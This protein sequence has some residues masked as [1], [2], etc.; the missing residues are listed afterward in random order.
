MDYKKVEK[1]WKQKAFDSSSPRTLSFSFSSLLYSL[2]LS[3]SISLYFFTTSFFSFFS[4]LSFLSFLIFSLTLFLLQPPTNFSPSFSFFSLSL[5]EF[6]PRL[7]LHHSNGTF[8]LLFFFLSSSQ[9]AFFPSCFF[10]LELYQNLEKLRY[11][12]RKRRKRKREG[13]REGKQSLPF[14]FGLEHLY[15]FERSNHISFL[16]VS[17]F[18]RTSFSLNISL[19]LSK[20]ISLL[21]HSS[22]HSLRSRKNQV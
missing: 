11:E 13:R 7:I 3:L 9:V 14:R 21:S 8:S 4:T 5:Y 20:R 18:F 19:M 10:L 1:R 17:L 2:S 15:F 16:S 22:S 6:L 12:R